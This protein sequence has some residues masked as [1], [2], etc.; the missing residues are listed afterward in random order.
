MISDKLSVR[1]S[2]QLY[3]LKIILQNL[4]WFLQLFN[5]TNKRINRILKLL[6][7]IETL[8]TVFAFKFMV[9]IV[10]CLSRLWNLWSFFYT[11]NKQFLLWKSILIKHLSMITF[12]N[13]W[14][15]YLPIH[16]IFRAYCFNILDMWNTIVHRIWFEIIL[17]TFGTTHKWLKIIQ[18]II[19][20]FVGI[21]EK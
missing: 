16:L 6:Q 4:L 2:L 9:K 17:K 20:F 13:D 3:L 12:I 15:F 7:L 10:S 18:F 11:F 19:K 8:L 14:E 21:I 5:S 1:F